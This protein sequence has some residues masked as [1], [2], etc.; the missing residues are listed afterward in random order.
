MRMVQCCVV[1][2]SELY[3][4]AGVVLKSFQFSAAFSGG[5]A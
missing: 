5:S 2:Q 3:V 4:F 1:E